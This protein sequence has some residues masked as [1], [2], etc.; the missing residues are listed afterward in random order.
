[1]VGDNEDLPARLD[2]MDAIRNQAYH[3]QW[4]IRNLS[5]LT[6]TTNDAH[7]RN[8]ETCVQTLDPALAHRFYFKT[9]SELGPNWR[10]PPILTGLLEG[11]TT[12]A[13][14]A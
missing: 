12:T 7:A 3:E 4:G 10:V 6:I 11:L 13:R 14:G 5:V 2:R 9:V 1:M 8:L